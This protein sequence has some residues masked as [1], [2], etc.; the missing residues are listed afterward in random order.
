MSAKRQYPFSAWVL[1][2]SFKPVEIEFVS[3]SWNP[4]W[5][6]TESGKRVHCKDHWHTKAEA[7]AVGRQRIADK[8]A[9][10]QKS[11]EKLAK[12]RSA[13]DKAENQ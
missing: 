9:A 13:L 10:L 4:E 3:S 8:E 2:P 6:R 11:L 12:Y 1:M 7:I 5:S